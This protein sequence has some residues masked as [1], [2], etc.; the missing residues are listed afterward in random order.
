MLSYLVKIHPPVDL[1]HVVLQRD[2]E[3][4]YAGISI[5]TASA[6]SVS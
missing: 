5:T 4:L 2:V 6:S 3:V 1:Q